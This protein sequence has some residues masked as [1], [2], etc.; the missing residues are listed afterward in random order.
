MLAGL[1][2]DAILSRYDQ[3]GAVD[4]SSPGDHVLDVVRVTRHVDVRV[5]AG[6]G[7]VLDVREIDR[8]PAPL[9]LGRAIDAVERCE[10]VPHRIGIRKHPGNRGGKGCLAV[11]D[12]TD[13]ADVHVRLVAHELLLP[14]RP[15]SR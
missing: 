1:W 9:L 2:H 7:L 6:Q 8:D 12:V 14:H 10:P 5:V 4:L 13:S 11:V 15:S 3:D